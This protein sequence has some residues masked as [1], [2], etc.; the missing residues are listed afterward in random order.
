VPK[1]GVAIGV[2]AAF[3]RLAV[4][5]QAVA[6]VTQLLGHPLMT[7]P[8]PLLAQFGS[9]MAH[10][11]A[12]PTQGGLRITPRHRLDELFEI[13]SHASVGLD[14]L[15]PSA[16]WTA[17]TSWGCT[18]LGS[19]QFF[20]PVLNDRARQAGGPGDSGDPTPADGEGFGCCHGAASPLVEG[21]CHAG[22]PGF[23]DLLLFHAAQYTPCSGL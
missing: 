10:T 18:R 13:P 21:L 12:R 15:L 17:D 16:A 1:L 6:Q 2:L 22:E 3:P 8:V 5:L 14:G 4:G 7:D 9:Q 11:F 20:D 19:S 23:D